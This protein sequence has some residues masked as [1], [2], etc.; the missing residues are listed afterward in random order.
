MRRPIN[1]QKRDSPERENERS[2]ALSALPD[3]RPAKTK[4]GWTLAIYILMPENEGSRLIVRVLILSKRLTGM[5]SV[6]FG[7]PLIR[8]FV[9]K[10]VVWR[11][12]SGFAAGGDPLSRAGA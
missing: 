1:Q 3:T 4:P 5:S 9:G 11:G 10:G 2:T 8:M 7:K 12:G 6:G